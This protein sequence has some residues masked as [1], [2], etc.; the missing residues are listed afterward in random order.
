MPTANIRYPSPVRIV[1]ALR[2]TETVTHDLVTAPPASLSPAESAFADLVLKNQW[3]IA[4]VLG[5]ATA[6]MT[7]PARMILA[8]GAVE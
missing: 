6:E 8:T 7:A 3:G 1:A 2:L 4:Q 5:M